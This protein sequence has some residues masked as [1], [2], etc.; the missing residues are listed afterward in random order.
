MKDSGTDYQVV[1]INDALKVGTAQMS[2]EALRR[3][4]EWKAMVKELKRRK[5]NTS[6]NR[7]RLLAMMMAR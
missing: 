4:P 7:M 6:A 1:R 5:M 3:S 2:A